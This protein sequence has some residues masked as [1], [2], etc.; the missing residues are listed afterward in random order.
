MA[1]LDNPF[2][3]SGHV[4]KNAKTDHLKQEPQLTP[5]ITEQEVLVVR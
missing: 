1:G 3:D 4:A 5:G 2:I